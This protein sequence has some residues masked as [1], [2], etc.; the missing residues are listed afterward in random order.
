[1]LLT[2]V[3]HFFRIIKN[4]IRNLCFNECN[5]ISTISFPYFDHIEINSKSFI[6]CNQFFELKIDTSKSIDP[7][8]QPK[9]L[10]ALR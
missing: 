9:Y 10:K 8:D 3:L 2:F 6:N 1:M 5:N 7:I 4:L